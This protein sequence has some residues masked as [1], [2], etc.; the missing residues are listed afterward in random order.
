MSLGA[1]ASEGV[2]Q[3]QSASTRTVLIVE[4]EP[5]IRESLREVLEDE[6]YAVAV[7]ANGKE[8]LAQLSRLARPCAVVLDIIMPVMSGNEL[9]NAMQADPELAA[10][11][12]LVSTSDPTRAP[13]GVLIMKKPIDVDRFLDAVAKLF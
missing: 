2:N 1:L 12:V 10:I 3:R 9:Y 7:A 5:D 13:S 4:D 6:G 11:P 8:G